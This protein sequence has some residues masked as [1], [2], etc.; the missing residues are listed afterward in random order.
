MKRVSRPSET[1]TAVQIAEPS[2]SQCAALNSLQRSMSLAIVV[3][4]PRLVAFLTRYAAFLRSNRRRRMAAREES[5]ESGGDSSSNSVSS[6]QSSTGSQWLDRFVNVWE[7]TLGHGIPHLL[8][9]AETVVAVNKL[10]YLF[11]LVSFHHPL[12]GLLRMSLVRKSASTQAQENISLTNSKNGVETVSRSSGWSAGIIMALLLTLRG[13]EW[14][15]NTDFDQR[16]L[17]R[18]LNQP[19]LSYER[20]AAPFPAPGGVVPPK[21]PSQFDLCLLCRGKRKNPCATPS[22]YVY[23]YSCITAHLRNSAGRT[24][25]S[26]SEED[27][28][29]HQGVNPPGLEPVTHTPCRESE[30]VR[31][32]EER[33]ETIAVE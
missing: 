25:D 29:G 1:S 21:D 17:L 30:L 33:T 4:V 31:L 8:A 6:A 9:I 3:L 5:G 28:V 16:S 26:D 20:P 32:Y 11:K 13:A 27:I 24:S 7:I 23:C 2:S 22:G 19:R 14:L 15:S 10:L 12:F 18:K